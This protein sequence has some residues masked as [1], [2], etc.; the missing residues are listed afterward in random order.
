MD[1][2]DQYVIYPQPHYDKHGDQILG[3]IAISSTG[4]YI[5]SMFEGEDPPST[6]EELAHRKTLSI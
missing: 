5:T 3:H 6:V 4:Q 1:D 2:D